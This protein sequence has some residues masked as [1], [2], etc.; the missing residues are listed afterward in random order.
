MLLILEYILAGKKSNI[1]AF[2]N[3][4]EYLFRH[5]VLYIGFV[6]FYIQVVTLRGKRCCT[7]KVLL[8][9]YY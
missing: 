4:N 1:I 5:M 2:I 3:K 8:R 6:L 9:F 7:S